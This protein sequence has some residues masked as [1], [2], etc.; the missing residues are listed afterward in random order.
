MSRRLE[1]LDLFS[2]PSSIGFAHVGRGLD[3][4]DELEDG[5]ADA[6]DAYGGTGDDAENTTAEKDGADEDVD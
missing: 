1:G 3:R 2:S 4:G 6:D 5:V